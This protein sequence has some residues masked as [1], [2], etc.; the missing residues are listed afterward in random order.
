MVLENVDARGALLYYLVGRYP[1]Y[2]GRRQL[3]PQVI[4]NLIV[5]HP[6]MVKNL[7]QGQSVL[8]FALKQLIHEVDVLRGAFG[9]KFNFSTDYLLSNLTRVAALYLKYEYTLIGYL[10]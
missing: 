10:P 2:R 3:L 7:Y 6:G 8:G 1:D 9:T 5:P 4:L